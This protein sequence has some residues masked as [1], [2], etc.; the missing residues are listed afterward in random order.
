VNWTA[1]YP[2]PT[3]KVELGALLELLHG[4]ADPFRTVQATYRTWRH[5]E[6]LR[7]ALLADAEEQ[8]RRGAH[9]RTFSF[10]RSGDPGPPETEETVRIWRDG[11]RIRE[12]HHGVQRDGNHSVADGPLWW[13]WTE[14]TGATSNQ[15]DPSVGGGV[16][17][18][19]QVMLNPTPLL[20][21]LRFRVA[22]NSQVAGRATVTAHATPQPQDPRH[23]RFLLELHQLGTGADHYQLE[24]DQERGML[25][26]VTAIRDEQPFYKITTLAIGFDEPIPAETFQFVPPEGEEIQP[27]QSHRHSL[28]RITLTEVQRAPFTVPMPDRVPASSTRRRRCTSR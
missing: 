12:E 11:Q 9:I 19:L 22:G 14:Q 17:Q 18:E 16:G 24:V 2:D 15:D 6:R 20:S 27:A 25:L 1:V 5:A 21:F 13:V 10:V 8:K 28:R 26:A 7:E 3:S 4:A 23:G